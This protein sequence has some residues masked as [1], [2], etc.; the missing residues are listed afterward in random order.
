MN[1]NKLKYV[2]FNFFW[3]LSSFVFP[4]FILTEILS[5]GIVESSMVS[6]YIYLLD[7][8]HQSDMDYLS[9]RIKNL[10][11]KENNV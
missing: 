3:C 8:R 11:I 7:I 4:F 5:I 10:E 9:E 1:K 2:P 6:F